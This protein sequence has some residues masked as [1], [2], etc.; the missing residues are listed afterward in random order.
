MAEQQ[1]PPQKQWL[2]GSEAAMMPRPETL[3][4]EG[5]RGSG[6][7]ANKAA[8]VTGGDTATGRSV[9]ALFAR[10]DAD[11]AVL[12]LEEHE[13]AAEPKRLVKE[14]GRRWLVLPGLP[15]D[16]AR[17]GRGD[18]PQG[19]RRRRRHLAAHHRGDWRTRGAADRRAALT[20][21]VAIALGA[22][23]TLYDSR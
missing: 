11:V 10:E 14:A 19:R 9:A 18:A 20:K 21:L 4:P 8:I 17:D 12:Y 5:Y 13:D 22:P 6:K 15:G 2:P 1:R 23:V 7:L 16:G 3:P